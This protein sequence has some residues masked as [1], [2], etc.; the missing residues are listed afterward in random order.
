MR[1]Q[2]EEKER[3]LRGQGTGTGRGKG[4]KLNYESIVL[5]M[6]QMLQMLQRLISYKATKLKRFDKSIEVLV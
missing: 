2:W 5:Q 3:K 1:G 6:L 4:R